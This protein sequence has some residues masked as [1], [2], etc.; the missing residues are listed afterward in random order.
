MWNKNKRKERTV[1]FKI[2]L[3][4]GI[5]LENDG[6]KKIEEQLYLPKNLY[7]K[8][9]LSVVPLTHTSSSEWHLQETKLI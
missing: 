3:W 5:L 8:V 7:C 4:K 6:M 1:I 2:C 9:N